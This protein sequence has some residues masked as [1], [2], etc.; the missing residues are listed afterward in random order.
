MADST[1]TERLRHYRCNRCERIRAEQIESGTPES[2]ARPCWWSTTGRTT[3]R[4]RGVS[5]RCTKT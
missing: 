2:E 5:G 1:A 4:A 3:A